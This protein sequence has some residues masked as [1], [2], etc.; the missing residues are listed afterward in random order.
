MSISDSPNCGITHWRN[1]KGVIHYR[2]SF[3]IRATGHDN[4]RLV[5]ECF[6]HRYIINTSLRLKETRQSTDGYTTRGLGKSTYPLSA[7]ANVLSISAFRLKW[8]FRPQCD[9]SMVPAGWG[10]GQAAETESMLALAESECVDLPWPPI[11]C[12]ATTPFRK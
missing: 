7:N 10:G 9:V 3:I 1:T 2:N 6:L 5:M 11:M 8:C 4:K 12:I